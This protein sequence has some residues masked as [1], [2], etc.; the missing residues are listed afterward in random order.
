MTSYTKVDST[1]LGDQSTEHKVLYFVVGANPQPRPRFALWLRL[2]NTS[3][4][5]L[6]YCCFNSN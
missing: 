4:Q 3:R 6:F 5:V 2:F 1:Q